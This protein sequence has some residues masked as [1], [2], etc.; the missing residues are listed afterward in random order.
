MT[1]WTAGYVADIGYT[2]GYYTELNPARV[3]LAFL[4]AGLVAPEFG[5]ACELGF[6]QG[7]SANLHAAASVTRWWGT[8]FNPSQAAFAQELGA[9]AGSGVQLFDQAFDEFAHRDDM[10]EFDYIGL[11]GIWS[12][13]SDENR[14][15][16]VDF[17]RRKLRVGGVLY[18]SYNTQPGWA[19]FAPMRH[20][21]NVHADVIGSE[22]RGIVQRIDD[23]LDFAGK[24]LALDPA[25]AKMNPS[26]AERLGKIK[27]QSRQY[28]AHEFFNR[29]WHPMH[30]STIAE[31]LAPA[32]VQF[33]C[34]ASYLDHVAAVNLTTEQQAF[35]AEISDPIFRETVRDFMT[36]Q[37]FRKDYWV[38]GL[39]QLTPLEKVEALREQKLVMICNPDD[40]KLQISGM[41]GTVNLN[42]AVYKPIIELLSD[43]APRAV[44]EIEKALHGSGISFAALEQA[45]MILCAMNAVSSVH[46]VSVPDAVAA[47]VRKI[48]SHLIRRARVASDIG[49]LASPLVAG[50]VPVDRLQQLFLMAR[51]TGRESAAE[52]ASYAWETLKVQGQR[53]MKEG[54]ALE[55]EDANLAELL[56][57]AETFKRKR[58]PALQA[59]QVV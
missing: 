58:L 49:V 37:Q 20:L 51:S 57:R 35:L 56:T 3:K 53:I 6:G 13:I 5:T 41:V 21:M 32:K 19:N 33:A 9:V 52:W 47:S 23:A 50:G 46:C 18:I 12:W 30:F 16:I 2:Y 15:V 59:L 24:L 43:C 25:Y 22:G 10:P 55:G 45:L 42:E 8:D 7:V 39:R 4:R 40:I 1:D 14:A 11:H 27:G 28:L 26:T 29:D 34:S 36:N 44:A 17:I 31:W 48:N 38:K 54:V